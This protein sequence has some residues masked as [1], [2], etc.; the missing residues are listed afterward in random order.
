VH[1][2]RPD[3]ARDALFAA[4]H[5]YASADDEHAALDLMRKYTQRRPNDTVALEMIAGLKKK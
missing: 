4:C 1:E 2:Q 5:A 3:E